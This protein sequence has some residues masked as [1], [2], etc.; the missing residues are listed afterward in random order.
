VLRWVPRLTFALML[1]PVVAGLAGTLA[2]AFGWLPALGGERPGLT[3][4]AS[5][6]GWPGLAR[7]VMLSATTGIGATLL[8]LVLAAVICAGWQGTR[9]FRM[10]EHTLSPMLAVPHAAAAFGMAF[11]IA[12]SGWLVRLLSPWAT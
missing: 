7:A 1:A 11:L 3:A 2:P 6:L 12:P 5:L 10:I 9:V 8:S 4:F